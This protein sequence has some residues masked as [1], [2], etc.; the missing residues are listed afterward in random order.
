[1]GSNTWRLLLTFTAFMSCEAIDE[2]QCPSSDYGVY[3]GKCYIVGTI[4]GIWSTTK[5]KCAQFGLS[6]VGIRTTE[7]LVYFSKVATNMRSAYIWVGATDV[8]NEG[9]FV[10]EDTRE[11]VSAD[12]LQSIPF[13][14]NSDEEDCLVYNIRYGYMSAWDCEG[15]IAF[16]ICMGEL[17]LKDTATP[18]QPIITPEPCIEKADIAFL[19]DASTSIGAENWKYQTQIAANITRYFDVGS[20]KVRFAAIIFNRIPT[21][22]F[23]LKDR[24]DHD[25]LSQALLATAYPGVYG[26]KTY[27]ALQDITNKNMFGAEAG[28]RDDAPDN[29]IVMTDGQSDETE[30]TLGAAA[31]LKEAGVNIVTVEIGTNPSQEELQ[32]LASGQQNALK[33]GSSDFQTKIVKSLIKKT[34]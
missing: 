30:K 23:D 20:D 13:V 9:K 12:F 8:Q 28:G 6:P 16:G 7:D 18:S 26:T 32:K 24:L 5:A 29:V 3:K 19:L 4:S 11:P 17:S 34:C 31:K 2:V 1:M 27:L 15:R 22:Q 10:W 14:S 25:S 33:A 21:L